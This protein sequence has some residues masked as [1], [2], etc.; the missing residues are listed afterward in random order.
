MS[1]VP[2][3]D[4]RYRTIPDRGH[5]AVAGVSAGGYSAMAIA[6]RH[7]DM[8]V[9]AAAFSGVVD[10][11]DRGPAGE[12]LVELPQTLFVD[13]APDELFR[14]FGNPYIDPLSWA[15]RNPADLVRN[16]RNV[17]LYAGAGDGTPADTDEAMS[18]G[19]F[20]WQRMFVENQI[21]SMT[22]HFVDDVRAAGIPITH[23]PHVGTHDAR[24]WRDDLARWW[25]QM[26][27]SL[28][29]APPASFDY[30]GA[31]ARFSVWGWTFAADPK[32]AR[33]FLDITTASPSA[34]TLTGSGIE[35]VTTASTFVPGARVRLAGAQQTEAVADTSGHITFTVDLGPP[36]ETTQFA[37]GSPTEP[38]ATRTVSISGK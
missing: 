32:R 37:A 27:S 34:I 1:L 18:G 26:L 28:G 25:P 22:A 33:E 13:M 31:E 35:L 16:L 3:V 2:R 30:R 24:H 10:I 20:L 21:S 19:A 8:F 5:R 36:H 6:A 15:E 23:R 7:P 4:A 12:A 17:D 9:A 29:T 14:R 11:R 38:F